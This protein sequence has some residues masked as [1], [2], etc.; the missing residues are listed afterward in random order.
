MLKPDRIDR[1]LPMVFPSGVKVS[2]FAKHCPHCKTLVKAASMNGIALMVV[3]R[4]FI[5]SVASCPK[6]QHEFEVKCMFDDSK[7][8]HPVLLPTMIMRFLMQWHARQMLRK[9]MPIRP[10]SPN[11]EP[12][13]EDSGAQAPLGLQ[14][15]A[16]D[17]I[18]SD[19]LL[20]RFQGKT[21]VAWIEYRGQRYDYDRA[22]PEKGQIRLSANE[23]LFDGTLVYRRSNMA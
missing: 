6:C 9:G 17:V 10:V 7:Q 18:T 8:V 2:S 22:V 4:V 1:Y 19:E 16:Q 21:I 14:L 20:G 13:K 3:D 12:A 15:S 5:L 11:A 23:A